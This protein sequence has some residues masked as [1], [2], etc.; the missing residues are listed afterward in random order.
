MIGYTFEYYKYVRYPKN[1]MADIRSCLYYDRAERSILTFGEYDRLKINKITRFDRFRDLSSLAKDWVG[2]RQSILLYN[3]NSEPEFDYNDDR[4]KEWGFINLTTGQYDHHLFWALTELPFRSILREK[5]P[6]YESLLQYARKRLDEIICSE[7]TDSDDG[8]KYM[9]LGILGTF[10]ISVFWLSNQYTDVLRMVNCIKRDSVYEGEQMYL[11][12]HTMFSKNPVYN[13]RD[14]CNNELIQAIEGKAL[15]QITLKKWIRDG[16]G[17][18]VL[19]TSGEYDIAKEIDAKEAFVLFENNDFCNHDTDNYQ[20]DILQTRVILADIIISEQEADDNLNVDVEQKDVNNQSVDKCCCTV[21][22]KNSNKDCEETTS[23]LAN[24]LIKVKDIYEELRNLIKQKIGSKTGL[25]DTLDSLHCD[26]R[27]NVASAVNQS[28]AEDFSYIFLKN[29]ECIKEILS[30]SEHDDVEFMAIFRMVLNNLKQQ[31]FHISEANGLNFE[32]PKCHLRYTGQEDCILFGYMG[33]IKEILN[34]AYQLDSSNKQTEIIPIVSVDVVPI[35]E[36]DLYFDKSQFADEKKVDQDFKILSL[37][38]PHVTFY[39]IPPNI[40]YLHHEIFHYIIPKDREERDY[41]MGILLTSIYFKEVLFLAFNNLFIHQNALAA[42]IVSYI[43]PLIF[44]I[45]LHNYSEIHAGITGFRSCKRKEDT[46]TVLLIGKVYKEKVISYLQETDV[47]FKSWLIE[48][49]DKLKNGSFSKLSFQNMGEYLEKDGLNQDMIETLKNW[50]K[51]GGDGFELL[52]TDGV[53]ECKFLIDKFMDGIE[54]IKADIPMIELCRMPLDEYLMT[55]V[56]CL[57]NELKTPDTINLS[58][59]L[60][61]FIRVGLILDYYEQKGYV[62]KGMKDSFIYK[63]I[64]KY[65]NFYD[66]S[67]ETIKRKIESRKN[68]AQDWFEF[69]EKCKDCYQQQFRLYNSCLRKLAKVFSVENRLYHYDI[70]EKSNIYFHKYREVYDKFSKEIQKIES[71]YKNGEKEENILTYCRKAEDALQRDIFIENIRLINYFQKQKKLNELREINKKNNEKKANRILAYQI[72]TVNIELHNGREFVQT[73]KFIQ[74]NSTVY[75]LGNF[76]NEINSVAK[77]L[78]RSC[79][80]VLGK[81]KYP[82]WYRGQENSDYGL[83]PSIM[84][85]NNKE[86][87]KF[88]YI[89]QYQR[90]LFEE[91]KYRAD[92]APE[93]MDR[94]YYGISDYLSLMQH[95]EV[96]TNLMDWSEDAFTGLYFALEKLITH[97]KQTP[98]KDAAIFVFSPHL[99]ND[100]RRHMIY[101]G[102]ESTACMESA[103]LASKR[104]ANHSDGLIP[105]IAASYNAKVYDVFLTGNLDYESGNHYGQIREMSLRGTEEMAYLPLAVY[106]SR[107]NPRIRSQSGIFVAYNLYAEPSIIED[108][109]SY[110]SMEKVQEYYLNECKR[111]HKEQFLYKII[112]DRQAVK[113][114]SECLVRM[115]I[116]KERIYPELANIGKRIRRYE[117]DR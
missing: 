21:I 99:Y 16:L 92:G 85:K 80:K 55:Y 9:I 14:N 117:F 102:A 60:K 58:E 20:N 113:E 18:S 48:L 93:V 36:S 106:T 11:A 84:R 114:I 6:D 28:W 64:A 107:L 76:L 78:E 41:I 112:I 105:N 53:N 29:L 49:Y 57:K 65:I 43:Q 91:F 61:E 12:A 50:C 66:D 44:D 26:Y 27:Y 82:L 77:A 15:V 5:M 115:G 46:D 69:F 81:K 32:L 4:D 25:I 24:N 75:N 39:D 35:V 56:H 42:T 98:E 100:A 17:I 89:S 59:D 3:F 19:H 73:S 47:L 45:V 79:Y 111:E 52:M 83:L 108:S 1:S 10:G 8:C 86:K 7:N 97:E 95:Y 63:Y 38:L 96:N 23:S 103:Y 70:E 109:Y 22:N 33:I 68:E 40:Q 94:S 101:E 90:S 67:V 13:V 72:P 71:L 116:S 110:M 54:E 30:M 87:E 2:N 104:T 62:L 37:N 31:I 88:N 51:N 74:K 34:V